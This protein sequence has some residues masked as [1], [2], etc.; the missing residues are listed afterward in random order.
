MRCANCGRET[1]ARWKFC[2]SCGA[3][4]E[5]KERA[6]FGDVFERMEREMSE[7]NKALE[8]NF[9][10]AD[11]IP[12]FPKNTKPMRGSGFSI[13]ITQGTGHKP[14]V[15]IQTFGDVP[16]KA[17]EKEAD[18]MGFGDR[19]SKAIRPEKTESSGAQGICFDSAK[20]TEEPVTCMKKVGS[21]TLVE[22]KLP[23]VRNAN[24][25]EVKKLE[26]SIEVKAIAGEKAYFKI[27]T[28]PPETSIFNQTFKNGVLTIELA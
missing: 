10:F 24:D 20:H 7:M 19:I 9:E 25:I 1:D 6:L 14:K 26:N 2:P 17:I 21:K 11:L 4:L 8:K 13:K 18:K 27:L 3:E 16:K 23:G 5:I 15:S 22:I 28:K 12:M